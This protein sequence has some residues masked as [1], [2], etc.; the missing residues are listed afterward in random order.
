[1]PARC[2]QVFPIWAKG[3]PADRAG[4]P[5]E[6][7]SFGPGRRVPQLDF[8]AAGRGELVAGGTK[9]N[10]ADRLGMPR[11]LADHFLCYN[12]PDFDMA[13]SACRREALVARMGCHIGKR[14]V[15]TPHRIYFFSGVQVPH[16][17]R[18]IEAGGSQLPI[19]Y[20]YGSNHVVRM[21]A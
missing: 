20:E 15:S 19:G 4:V 17:N 12:I 11:Q 3:K 21:P 8:V 13:I 16:A 18:P 9:C 14:T 5:A 6:H 10:T 7:V 2:S 1:L